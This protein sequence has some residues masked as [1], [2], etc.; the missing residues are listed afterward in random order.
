M[1]RIRLRL[2]DEERTFAV[3]APPESSLVDVLP[4]ARTLTDQATQ[5][6]LDHL[7]ESG[8]PASCKSGCGACCRQLVAVSL[9]EAVDLFD[10]VTSLPPRRRA[11][12]RSRFRAGL[13]RLEKAGMLEADETPG[14]RVLLAEEQ[15]TPEDTMYE[16]SRRYFHLGIACPFLESESCSIYERRPA[17]CREYHV[18][19][20]PEHCSRPD[21]MDVERVEPTIGMTSALAKT[22][23]RLLGE[24]PRTMPLLVA[25]EWAERHA[26]RLRRKLDGE[27]VLSVLAGE[28]EPTTGC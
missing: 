22:T 6:I 24:R 12:I 20:P 5:V 14:D 11:V 10:L 9:P 23:H 18:L 2:L 27:R 16:L 21:E 4:A 3:P 17:V 25:L 28:L 15:Q 8:R 26:E 13:R 7:R 19:T 1:A